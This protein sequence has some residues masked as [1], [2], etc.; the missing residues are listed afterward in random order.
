MGGV[1]ADTGD[2]GADIEALAIQIDIA[3]FRAVGLDGVPWGALGLM[4]NEDN[5]VSLIAEHGFQV[6]DDTAA[7]AHAATGDDDG[8]T[9]G[10]GQVIDDALVVRVA[11][12]GEELLEGQRAAPGADALA[13]FLVPEGLQRSVGFGETAGQG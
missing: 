7:A 13:G 4:A 3:A 1:A 9:G 11:I 12:D 5:V 8:G 2:T 10:L 6:I